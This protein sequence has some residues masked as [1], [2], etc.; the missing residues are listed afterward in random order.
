MNA[1]SCIIAPTTP[2]LDLLQPEGRKPSNKN[3][4][5]KILRYIYLL[6]TLLLYFVFIYIAI[7]NIYVKCYFYG[8][9]CNLI[10]FHSFYHS[11]G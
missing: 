10:G 11:W 2:D 8:M 1:I 6:F 3:L 7:L 5:S 9:V 4:Y